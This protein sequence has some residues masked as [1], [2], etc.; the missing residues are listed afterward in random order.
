MLPGFTPLPGREALAGLVD[1]Y[2]YA[3]GPATPQHFAKWLAMPVNWAKEL[4]GSLAAQGRTERVSFEG[5]A[6]WVKA[7]DTDFPAASAVR[8]AVRGVRLLPYFDAFT[9]ASQPRTRLFA[10]AAYERALGGGQAGNFPVLLID[11]AVAGVW[12][13]RRSGKWID[14]TVEPLG[15]LTAAQRAGLGEQVE[16]TGEILQGTPRLTVGTVSVGAHA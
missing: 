10:G 7:G 14:V 12:H 1:H 3:Y 4:F 16:R 15:T 2:L 5:D 6:A 13:Q 9:I 11:G 8:G